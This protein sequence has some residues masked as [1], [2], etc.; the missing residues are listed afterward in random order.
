MLRRVVAVQYAPKAELPTAWSVRSAAYILLSRQAGIHSRTINY[1]L[2]SVT[3]NNIHESLLRFT[4]RKLRCNHI[5]KSHTLRTQKLHCQLV[6]AWAI[7]KAA[8][9]HGFLVTILTDR[10]VNPRRSQASLYEGAASFETMN[11]AHDARFDPR[12]INDNIGALTQL[13]TALPRLTR[14]DPGMASETCLWRQIASQ[15]PGGLL[16]CR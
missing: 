12:G 3:P 9:Q 15:R 16:K 1:G 11:P 14:E 10:E 4:E 2:D 13:R 8:L 7:P 5:S 6:I